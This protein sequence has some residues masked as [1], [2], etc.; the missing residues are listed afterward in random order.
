M[1]HRQRGAGSGALPGRLAIA[2]GS[3]QTLVA[4]AGLRA[5][6][7]QRAFLHDSPSGLRALLFQRVFLHDS[8]SGLRALA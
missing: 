7:F 4:R 5:L 3:D 8:P 2:K 6:L 1:W